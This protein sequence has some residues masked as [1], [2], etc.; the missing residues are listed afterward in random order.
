MRENHFF[1][2]MCEN[3]MKISKIVKKVGLKIGEFR[4]QKNKISL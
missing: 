2:K 1:E 3:N 4:S